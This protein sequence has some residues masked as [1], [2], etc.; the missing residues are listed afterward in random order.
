VQWALSAGYDVNGF[1]LDAAVSRGYYLMT[2]RARPHSNG[3][4]P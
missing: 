1:Y 4:R 2:K 3:V